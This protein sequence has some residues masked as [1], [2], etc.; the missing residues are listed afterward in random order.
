[1]PRALYNKYIPS[2]EIQPNNQPDGHEAS[3][4]KETL[5]DKY[6]EAITTPMDKRFYLKKPNKGALKSLEKSLTKVNKALETF[7]LLTEISDVNQLNNMVYA[8]A[9]IAIE[10]AGIQ[11]ECIS[12]KRQQQK[13]NNDWTFNMKRRIGRFERRYQPNLP[14]ESF[15]SINENKEKQASQLQQVT[16]MSTKVQF[17]LQLTFPRQ[18]SAQTF[19]KRYLV[20]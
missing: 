19:I 20:K 9:L 11:R 6:A 18:N 10:T 8:A 2:K 17:S 14:N 5:A 1:M 16:G 12:T 15:E 13:R 3:Q 4:I 7:P